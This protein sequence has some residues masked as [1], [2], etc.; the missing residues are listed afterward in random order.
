M[1]IVRGSIGCV[2]GPVRPWWWVH[3]QGTQHVQ[4]NRWVCEVAGLL[5][6]Q[7]NGVDE[8]PISY[9]FF[10]LIS[11]IKFFFY[12]IKNIS[13]VVKRYWL[14]ISVIKIIFNLYINKYIVELFAWG[15]INVILL[16]FCDFLKN[17]FFK[18]VLSCILFNN[19]L[20]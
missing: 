10:I 9:W 11:V 2:S 19:T 4:P 7:S 5:R 20:L 6:V 13:L 16:M 14:L 12:L 18:I 1:E 15:E 3:L 17:V 8:W